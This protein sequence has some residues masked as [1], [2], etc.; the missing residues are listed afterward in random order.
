MPTDAPPPQDSASR[1]GGARGWQ[2]LSTRLV[3]AFM[4]L[5]GLALAVA[6]MAT[7]RA[8]EDA[9]EE[10]IRDD[11]ARTLEAFQRLSQ[12]TQARLRDV[13]EAHA[14][15][16][17]FK[18]VVLTINSDDSAAGLDDGDAEL[19]GIQ[20]A[21][22]VILSADTEVFGWGKEERIWALFNVRKRLVFTHGD[23]EQVGAT[24][25]G[26]PVL[27]RA[28]RQGFA[29]ALWSPA[30]LRALPFTFVPKERLREGDLLLVQAQRVT[31]SGGE[32]GP[33]RHTRPIGVVLSGRWVKE[34]LLENSLEQG[35]SGAALRDARAR[36]ALLA[37]DGALATTDSASAPVLGERAF[38]ATGPLKVLIGGER[39]LVRE[40]VFR[41]LDGT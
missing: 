15:D 20:G 34:L 38:S 24:V 18:D 22:E 1:A 9:A 2:S 19:E 30:Q 29:S 16:R 21:H 40:D 23:D 5:A 12:A 8:V 39:H 27:E 32:S 41:D 17:T 11:L 37:A 33:E 10:K 7:T 4:L 6:L 28:L 3:L 31:T 14:R 36:F 13:A 25:D 26:L 35:P